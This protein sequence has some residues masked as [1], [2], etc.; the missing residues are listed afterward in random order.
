MKKFIKC[1]HICL[2]IILFISLIFININT[3]LRMEDLI[4]YNEFDKE[5]ILI[6]NISVSLLIAFLLGS[7]FFSSKKILMIITLCIYSIAFII[8]LFSLGNVNFMLI[9]NLIFSL[10]IIV[11]T[12]EILCN[13]KSD[14][15]FYL[16]IL[17]ICGISIIIKIGDAINDVDYNGI[18]SWLSILYNLSLIIAISP[19]IL[20][21]YYQ[22]KKS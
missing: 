10:G 12:I 17:I 4:R 3:F 19:Q 20:N 22:F 16:V 11:M 15:I 5:T 13:K 1:A 18:K 7:S 2:V 14:N 9:L 8:D 6:T 21:K